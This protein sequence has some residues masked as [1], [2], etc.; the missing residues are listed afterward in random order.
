MRSERNILK[1]KAIPSI[2][3][4]TKVIKR[5]KIQYQNNKDENEVTTGKINQRNVHVSL[6]TKFVKFMLQCPLLKQ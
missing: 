1:P 3:P 6:R 2:F 4:W 5:R